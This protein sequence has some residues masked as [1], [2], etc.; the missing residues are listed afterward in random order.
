MKCILL[1]VVLTAATAAGTLGLGAAT[2]KGN[3][4]YGEL[5]VCFLL[6]YILNVF[7]LIITLFTWNKRDIVAA[8]FGSA[9]S[10]MTLWALNN[11]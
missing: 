1:L 5:F 8:I 2:D 3:H 10:V 9:F 7:G 11:I 6:G 4:H